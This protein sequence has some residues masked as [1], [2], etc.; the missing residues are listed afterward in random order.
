MG[1]LYLKDTHFLN[2]GGI[3]MFT[4]TDYLEN[5]KDISLK[6]V[7]FNVLDNLLL[8]ILVYIPLKT[9]NGKKSLSEFYKDSQK[10]KPVTEMGEMTKSAYLLLDI[11]KDSKRY[12][13]L[14][15]HNFTN[16]T[17]DDTQFGA[18]TYR[19]GTK[20]IIT[21]KGTDSSLIGWIENFRITYSYPTFTHKKAI[22]YLKNNVHPILDKDIYIAGHSKGGNLSLVSA[23]EAP[24][25]ISKKIKKVY[26]FDG[27]GLRKEQYESVAYKNISE[28]TENILPSGSVIGVIMYNENYRVIKSNALAISQHY[29]ITWNVFGEFFVP[30]ILSN[31]S[32]QLH[33]NTTDG[34][35]DIPPEKMQQAFESVFLNLEQKFSDS[36]NF[37][38]EDI[39]KFYKNIKNLDPEISD[40]LDKTL[41]AILKLGISKN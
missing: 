27:P 24:Q 13:N 9:Y 40:V 10:V 8:A 28:K 38:F 1:I 31:I 20:T 15:F 25:N 29:P 4:I 18:C 5:Y 30:A 7:H 37:S 3:L 36:F 22:E 2:K 21:F 34:L 11:I 26:N 23:F 33:E 39:F 41:G 19:L 16:F 14:K 12:K 32:L 17:S 6:D 35:K